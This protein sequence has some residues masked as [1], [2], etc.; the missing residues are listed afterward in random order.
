MDKTI[1]VKI[2]AIESEL[3]RLWDEKNN[4]EIRACL[5]TLIIYT[6]DIQRA[7]YFK[8]LMQ[9]IVEKFPCRI[10]FVQESKD[11]N[12]LKVSVATQVISEGNALFGCDQI[13]IEAP[14]KDLERVPSI[15]IPHLVPDLPVYLIWAQDP[16]F[17]DKILSQL[18]KVSTRLIFDA[19]CSTN[20]QDFSKKILEL[21]ENCPI[22]TMDMNWAF[23]SGWRTVLTSTFDSPEKI[24]ELQMAHLIHIT[25]N[26]HPTNY[27]RGSET[28][29]IYLQGWIAAQMGWKF[30]STTD[31]DKI[32]TLK[33]T[34]G[35]NEVVLTLQQEG[36]YELPCGSI[37]DVE[38]STEE[39]HLF[40]LHRQPTLAKV[41]VHISSLEKCEL[42]F[43]LPL[44]N[45]RRGFSFVN[46]LFYDHPGPHYRNMLKMI[47]Q[48]DWKIKAP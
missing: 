25:Y 17:K 37:V 22:E 43:T 40:T 48:V 38:I 9:S 19:E 28:L 8:D 4:K 45:F 12:D 36:S 24:H 13:N 23:L 42:P 31:D 2:P 6:S 16:S 18:A 21:L 3:S 39:D 26:F 34:N 46:A 33:Y 44:P 27:I 7:H 11:N 29:A 41:V 32:R 5:F 10:I 47:S 35:S 20:L 15:V 1:E 14:S 30:L